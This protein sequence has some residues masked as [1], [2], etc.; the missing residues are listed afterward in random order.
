VTQ[1]DSQRKTAVHGVAAATGQA[2]EG[3]VVIDA[4]LCKGCEFCVDVCPEECL[5]M[6]DLIN[7]RGYRFAQ[8]EGDHCTGCGVCYYNCPEPGAIVV[9][10][11]KAQQKET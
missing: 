3:H 5:A 8:Y 4:E 1:A 11:S 2:R 6:A 7:S 9:T 10:K